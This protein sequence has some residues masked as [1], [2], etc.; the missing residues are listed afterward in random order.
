MLLC[1]AGEFAC[2]PVR[3]LHAPGREHIVNS[4]K[5]VCQGHAC[6]GQRFVGQQHTNAILLSCFRI[7]P[8]LF[9][10]RFQ[11]LNWSGKSRKSSKACTSIPVQVHAD[12]IKIELDANVTMQDPAG[13]TPCAD[14]LRARNGI[15]MAERPDI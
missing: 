6:V 1:Y 4:P 11:V 2:R 9:H 5:C 13:H 12:S 10:C 14:R 7:L 8:D 15:L 3:L